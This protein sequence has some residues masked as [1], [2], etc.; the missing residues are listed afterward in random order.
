MSAPAR[1]SSIRGGDVAHLI[2][3]RKKLL[4]IKGFFHVRES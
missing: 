3:A 1:R 4:W 2:Y